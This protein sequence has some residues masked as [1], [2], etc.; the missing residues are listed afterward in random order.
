MQLRFQDLS[1]ED[2]MGQRIVLINALIDFGRVEKVRSE[3]ITVCQ[4]QILIVQPTTI[5]I[6]RLMNLLSSRSEQE[7]SPSPEPCDGPISL[8]NRH[9]L[10]CVFQPHYQC[11]SATTRKSR[12]HFEKHFRG[13]KRYE[14][15]PCPDK[16][17]RLVLHGHQALKSHAEG[18]HSVLIQSWCIVSVN[19]IRSLLV[20]KESALSREKRELDAKLRYVLGFVF[21]MYR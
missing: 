21:C 17:C 5:R 4:K 14:P 9:C 1:E 11:Y 6:C 12:E 7:P 15:I 20:L 3:R 16:Y 8:T 18:V 19:A 10:F 13:F 2:E